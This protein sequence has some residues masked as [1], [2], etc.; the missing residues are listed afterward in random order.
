MSNEV[1]ISYEAGSTLYFRVFNSAGQ[2]WN[3]SGTPAFEAWAAGNVA[4]YDIALVDLSSGVYLGDFPTTAAGTYGIVA[5]DQAGG[6][7]AI[8]DVAIS[9]IGAIKWSGTAEIPIAYQTDVTDAHSTTD[10]LIAAISAE[11]LSVLNIYDESRQTRPGG[12]YP[13][14]EDTSGGAGV[15][16]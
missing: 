4:D 3:T 12:T 9:P 16:P 15:Y 2:V 5:F 14:I 13:I 1:K 6:T 11:V 8:T 7:P 10:A